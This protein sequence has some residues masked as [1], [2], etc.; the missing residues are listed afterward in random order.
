M[1][2]GLKP[3]VAGLIIAAAA[4][5]SGMFAQPPAARPTFDA[6]EVATVKPT[7]LDWPSGDAT[8]G[9]RPRISL[10]RGITR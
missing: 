8:C 10:S 7:T 1:Q 2:E 4:A 5:A 6:F 9:C 3:A